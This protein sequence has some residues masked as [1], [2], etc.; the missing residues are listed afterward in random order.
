[1]TTLIDRYIFT[2]LR[3]VPERQ[4][5]DIDRELRAS[6]ADAVEARL[7][8]GEP[9]AAA[10]EDSLRELG[11]PRRLADGYADR[12]Q[13]LI[14]PEMFPVWR[15]LLTVLFSTVLPL[16]VVVTIVVQVLERGPIV[17]EAIST[18]IT[19]AAHLAFWTT[20][21]FAILER[22]GVPAPTLKQRPW[23]PD[24]LP[25]YEPGFLTAAQLAGNL[26]WPVL[27][28][29]A[30]LL[31]HFAFHAPVLNPENWTF[32][33]PYL[34]VVL[35]LECVYVVWVFRRGAWSHTVTAVNATLAVL[36]AGPIIGLLLTDRWF[37]PGFLHGKASS[38]TWLNWT[39]ATTVAVI[40]VI[41]V[42]DTAIKA[43]RAR[44]ARAQAYM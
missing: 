5:P 44:R 11:D 40:A 21:T 16:V 13:Y 7:G 34:A 2:V 35:S 26:V 32:W 3:R 31:Q 33:W 37:N 24:D 17:G 25:W 6:I 30:L 38:S 29:V 22:T 36:S 12:P 27:L 41:D 9:E 42:A 18:A 20:A 4:R 28:L 1:M 19:V 23:T 8:A 14:G 15:R 39:L 10:V 43:E